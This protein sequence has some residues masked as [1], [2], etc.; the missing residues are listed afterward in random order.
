VLAVAAAYYVSAF[1]VL[2]SYVVSFG[3]DVEFSL[4]ILCFFSHRPNFSYIRRLKLIVL[5]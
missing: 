1:F 2:F 4:G 5:V 3:V